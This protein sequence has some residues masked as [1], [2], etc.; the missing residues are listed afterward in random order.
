[1]NGLGKEKIKTLVD[2]IEACHDKLENKTLEN[3]TLEN[4]QQWV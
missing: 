3:K 2:K 4:N 1:M